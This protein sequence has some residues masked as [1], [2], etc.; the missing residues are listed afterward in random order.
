MAS[1]SSTRV[2]SS[3]WCFISDGGKSLLEREYPLFANS[4]QTQHRALDIQSFTGVERVLLKLFAHPL[5]PDR[6]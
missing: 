4:A 3:R 1:G 6:G 2:S 5:G